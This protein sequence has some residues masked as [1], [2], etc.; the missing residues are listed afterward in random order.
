M[1][2]ENK[3][4]SFLESNYLLFENQV[5]ENE[6]ESLSN[7]IKNSLISKGIDGL[8]EY[9]DL[10][11]RNIFK[12]LKN[13]ISD[14]FKKHGTDRISDEPDKPTFL[15][16]F[17]EQYLI[18]FKILNEDD[19][20]KRLIEFFNKNLIESLDSFG[21]EIEHKKLKSLKENV[22][23]YKIESNSKLKD[24]DSFFS[25][26]LK[27]SKVSVGEDLIAR[28]C[29]KA[30]E[31]FVLA[32]ENFEDEIAPK[33]L[34]TIKANLSKTTSTATTTTATINNNN[35][36]TNATS[37][38]SE[39]S[40]KIN[41][42]VKTLENIDLKKLKENISSI[43]ATCAEKC[44]LS[45]IFYLNLKLLPN[46]LISVEIIDSKRLENLDELIDQELNLL[47]KRLVVEQ[48][49]LKISL[50]QVISRKK[51]NDWSWLIKEFEKLLK[52]MRP[53]NVFELKFLINKAKSVADLIL[54]QD[55]VL[56]LGKTGSGKSTTIHFLAGSQMIESEVELKS[57]KKFTHVIPVEPFKCR[58]LY[59]VAISSRDE[60]E[61]RY[62]HAVPV[63]FSI[64]AKHDKRTT[65]LC[66]TPGFGDTAGAEVGIANAIGVLEAIKGCKSVKP[67]ILINYL[68]VGG[69]GEGIKKLAHLLVRMIKNIEDYLSCFNYIFTKWPN[70]DIHTRLSN[71][72]E[73]SI[74]INQEESDDK[75][76]VSLFVD[77]LEKTE[78]GA[79]SLDP[80]NHKPIEFLKKFKEGAS[81]HNPKDVF[82]FSLDESTR[83]AVN[84]QVRIYQLSIISAIKR[85]EYEL[86]MVNLNDLKYLKDSLKEDSIES[87]FKSSVDFIKQNIGE[88]FSRNKDELNKIIDQNIRLSIED[89]NQY[90]KQVEKF[91][92][93]KFFKDYGIS[94]SYSE[95]MVK[96]LENKVND[97][98]EIVKGYDDLC[99]NMRDIK[100]ILDNIKLIG[101]D[102]KE[103]LS[104]YDSICN[105]NHGIIHVKLLSMNDEIEQ[106]LQSNDLDQ[107]S[108]KLSS[109]LKTSKYLGEHLNIPKLN[110]IYQTL[111]QKV[112]EHL[113]YSSK[114]ADYLLSQEGKLCE[115]DIKTLENSI[116]TLSNAKETIELRDHIEKKAIGDIYESLLKKIENYFVRLDEKIEDLLKF[117]PENYFKKVEDLIGQ[118]ND[119]RSISV[120]GLR[121]SGV[122]QSRIQGIIGFVQRLKKNAETLLDHFYK[123]SENVDY[124][125]F[126]R[127]MTVLRSA[128]W[129][130][131]LKEGIYEDIMKNVH[132]DLIKYSRKLYEEILDSNLNIENHSILEI[133]SKLL[134]K[135]EKMQPL[136]ISIKELVQFRE[137]AQKKFKDALDKNFLFIR[138]NFDLQRQSVNEQTKA[139]RIL[140]KTR[141]DYNNFLP[142]RIFLRN[143]GFSSEIVL[144]EEIDKLKTRLEKN[145]NTTVLL[146]QQL[147]ELNAILGDYYSYDQKKAVTQDEGY[148]KEKI[149][150]GKTVKTINSEIENC[151]KELENNKS[152][153]S[154]EATRLESL[155]LID[156]K[157]IEISNDKNSQSSLEGN[158]HVGKLGYKNLNHL[159][160]EIAKKRKQINDYNSNGL[161]YAFNRLEL[162]TA[163]NALNFLIR[164]QSIRSI[165]DNTDA[166]NL[167]RN[168]EK[169]LKKYKIYIEK[170]IIAYFGKIENLPPS[171]TSSAYS[172]AHELKF[173]S[174]ELTE[175]AKFTSIDKIIKSSEV[176]QILK[177]KVSTNLMD[178]RDQL[179][180]DEANKKDLKYKLNI[181]KAFTQLDELVEGKYSVLYSEYRKT[182]NSEFKECYNNILGH[183]E[184]QEYKKV[185]N[186]MI[187]IDDAPISEKAFE[188]VRFNLAVSISD[189]LAKTKTLIVTL[190]SNLEMETIKSIAENFNKLENARKYLTNKFDKKNQEK[191]K[192][193]SYL[194]E[195]TET[196]LSVGLINFQES[197]SKKLQKYL[198][199]TE[200]LIENNEFFLSEQRREYI[201]TVCELLGS[202]FLTNEINLQIA[203]IQQTL[204]RIVETVFK[205]YENM[206]IEDYILDPPKYFLAQLAQISKGNLKYTQT[207]MKVKESI[208]AK[209][210]NKLNEAQKPEERN[211]SL[212][213]VQ[214][215]MGSLPEDIRNVIEHQLEEI[216]LTIKNRNDDYDSDFKSVIE[217]HDVKAI[218]NFMDKCTQ[219]GM[220]SFLKLVSDEILKKARSLMDEFKNS[221]DNENLNT[222][223]DAFKKLF[224]YKQ[225]FGKKMSALENFFAETN[226]QLINKYYKITSVLIGINSVDRVEHVEVSFENFCKIMELKNEFAFN[227]DLKNLNE[228]SQ[229]I[230][231]LLS[232]ISEKL[233]IVYT[234]LTD[235][236]LSNQS[237]F[238][239]SIEQLNI[240]KLNEAMNNMK[241]WNTL[242]KQIKR[243]AS[244]QIDNNLK[245][246]KLK[247]IDD[248]KSYLQMKEETNKKLKD[249]KEKILQFETLKGFEKEL[250]VRYRDLEASVLFLKNSGEL[251]DHI[252]S[253]FFA[254][255]SFSEDIFPYL[256]R[257]FETM[258]RSAVEILES[259]HLN[260]KDLDDLRL[261]L[262]NL[263][264]FEKY[265]RSFGLDIKKS[266]EAINHKIREKIEKLSK[267]SKNPDFSLDNLASNLIEMKIFADNIPSHNERINES[268]DD[269]LKVFRNFKKDDG[270]LSLAKLATFLE[271]D[272]SGIGL[273]IISEHSIF[274]GQSISLFNQE[275]KRHGIDHILSNIEGDGLD[276]EKLR[277]LFDGFDREYKDLVKDSIHRL[278]KKNEI[279]DV[280][281]NLIAKIRL[282]PK[283]I[284][285]KSDSAIKWDAEIRYLVPSLMSHIFALWTLKNIE[286]YRQMKGVE[287]RDTYLCSPHPGQI[288]SIFRILGFG[289][290][291]NVETSTSKLLG[292]G[293][294]VSTEAINTD[295][296]QNNLVQIGTGEGKSVI[297]AVSSCVLALLGI[298][299]S[300]ACYSEYLSSRDYQSFL[301]I[302]DALGVTKYIHYGTFNAICEKI[303]NEKGDVRARIVN[304][305]SNKAFDST[306]PDNKKRPRI[307][308]IDE[309]DVFFS[310]DFYGNVY[311]P[312]ARLNDPTI[313]QL[314]KYI[315]TNR[316]RSLSFRNIEQSLEFKACCLRYKGWEFL[317]GEA[318]KDMLNDVQEYKHDYIVQHDKI[319]YK[320][321]DGVSFDL[322]Y[323]YKTLF[324]YFYENESGTVSKSSLEENISIGIKCGA[325][326]YAEIPKRFNYILGV[327]GTLKTISKSEK[328]IIEEAYN[329]KKKTYMPSVF[330][331]NKRKF[332]K[333]ADVFIENRDDY[334]ITLREKIDFSLTEN[335]RAVMVFFE[336]K[337]NLNEFLNSP[338]LAQLKVKLKL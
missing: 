89:V 195:D 86:A 305:V 200:A 328:Q 164:C 299:V 286:Y 214:S 73:T 292:F 98:V 118:M 111:V 201:N 192:T 170:A 193:K 142:A 40:E 251:K 322:V 76:F 212:R 66:D 335:K 259:N 256:S 184:K 22:L 246:D 188:Q 82:N 6:D 69:R 288:I 126:Y 310:K 127:C 95:A 131:S 136:E 116:V 62:I 123:Q 47:D 329:I 114:S 35:N 270:G 30:K 191:F 243:Y 223:L 261:N 331:E 254:V 175:I 61:T 3:L 327:T 134:V 237:I 11:S 162:N 315:W 218:F 316:S 303:I 258:T 19:L 107:V 233:E 42:R 231:I 8:D 168:V 132:E 198:D 119:M 93:L 211:Q 271:K 104:F 249:L 94:D 143:E 117:E 295:N 257:Q 238:V 206:K 265:S 236:F 186:E 68:D 196:Q 268:I 180:K 38:G 332:A 321:Q 213:I 244:T 229:E 272:P 75:S 239:S 320:E 91:E 302:F 144:N 115:N 245:S 308:L 1:S 16:S 45:L 96:N 318:V 25:H 99:L 112:K 336:S 205:K 160:E 228:S 311:T 50:E 122:Y 48:L 154:K 148:Q 312:L 337:K 152:I 227:S 216:K 72:K 202:F 167:K 151:E 109:L 84:E 13:S 276:T 283:N 309:V 70:V 197:V 203:G 264:Y 34:Q 77:I 250:E 263:S 37:N 159:E 306:E 291:E 273:T 113:E 54:N 210:R 284:K 79:K 60:S 137:S 43:R 240:S 36:N 52:I 158:E 161:D 129:V 282:L 49:D 289:Y 307:L 2:L 17:I 139:L 31:C 221:L 102:F 39:T 80:I 226:K 330:G 267:E 252:D 285:Q 181:V 165:R 183:I 235:Y 63:N 334:F 145:K 28:I 141:E 172:L 294:K 225:I 326:S 173:F 280:L 325:F 207:L 293:K 275:A 300:C 155:K 101:H 4:E 53:L 67:V 290:F 217:S 71:I 9:E 149:L 269:V 260:K 176:Q 247:K 338:N 314:A 85:S 58:E 279:E 224:E 110:E 324:A 57:G 83:N 146:N 12:Q 313:Q 32:L 178:L 174:Q 209:L 51:L 281:N 296:L 18:K 156:T 120:I 138:E 55:I 157:Y 121:T 333:E 27:S 133:I 128:E 297:L 56:L 163:E 41:E 147:K 100:V 248:G 24:F 278:E 323:G 21:Q 189:L 222:A 105:S 262:S 7:K 88:E 90:K 78:N 301:P 242:L 171:D 14:I 230:E 232:K 10:F 103:V 219:N 64:F 215:A 277:E 190:T 169:Y 23:S 81:I 298:S 319:G 241:K 97:C 177:E 65:I 253:D 15:F 199:N 108:R 304:L 153:S 92:G 317:I 135:L 220:N 204:E 87:V 194:D 29:E 266:L 182:I 255:S 208:I 125:N 130:N 74:D 187:E 124:S 46:S 44:V 179:D 166:E 20:H 185:A 234:N 33:N 26:L 106:S 59:D 274:K 140:E 5:T 150:K 287:N